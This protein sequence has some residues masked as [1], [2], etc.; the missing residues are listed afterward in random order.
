M[1]NPIFLERDTPII[2]WSTTI[3]QFAT[4]EQ[5]ALAATQSVRSDGVLNTEYG[6]IVSIPTI[7]AITTLFSKCMG[8]H[9]TGPAAGTAYT[10]YQISCSVFCDD[11]NIKPLLMVG[12]SPASITNAAGG[13]AV[14]EVRPIGVPHQVGPEGSALDYQSV[15]LVNPN[16]LDRGLCIF[17]AMIAGGTGAAPRVWMRLSARRLIGV[18]PLVLDTRKS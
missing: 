9:L 6:T 8:L 14:T 16:T 4:T 13:N 10:P 17:V 18:N 1:S 7:T 12:E 3:N 11:V 15:I 5:L 2:N